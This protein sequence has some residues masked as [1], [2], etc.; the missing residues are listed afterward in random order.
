MAI[1]KRYKGKHRKSDR[2]SAF[3][4]AVLLLAVVF[5]AG[6]W[7]LLG[8]AD[9]TG[10]YQPASQPEQTARRNQQAEAAKATF[11]LIAVGDIM[12]DR[13]VSSMINSAGAD[14]PFA[15]TAD[16]LRDADVTFA[17]LETPLATGGARLMEK[18]VTFRGNP[19]AVEGMT[20][21]GVDVVSLANNH[22]FDY[23]VGAY[24]ET[25]ETL[26]QHGVKHAGA[27]LDS[28]EAHSP[29]VV[30]TDKGLKVG[31][32]MYTEIIPKWFLPSA[33][34]HGVAS[35]RQEPARIPANI[36]S[37]KGEVDFVAV[38]IHWGVEYSST[39]NQVQQDMGRF[40]IDSGADMV[41]GH[42]PH[43]IQGIEIYNGK[44]IAYSLGNF[45]FDRFRGATAESIILRGE[46]DQ[47]GVKSLEITPVLISMEGQPRPA[48]GADGAVILNRLRDLSPTLAGSTLVDHKLIW[49]RAR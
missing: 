46:F 44:L 49:E 25:V 45:I 33:S 47:E 36:S 43:V 2:S 6:A 22:I 7:G 12:F 14:W 8:S 23:G 19:L 10:E 15:R 21:A 31:F 20:G 42:H 38:S 13:R 1:L 32:L 39:A 24:R 11:S 37:L 34:R 3:P 9:R 35:V 30:V 41:L 26:D 29:A 5:L 48:V 18:D 40:L 28:D 4:P 27:G 16:L 17:N